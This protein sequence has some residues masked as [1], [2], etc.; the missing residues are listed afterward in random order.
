MY[1]HVR[2]EFSN[3][4][5]ASEYSAA[6]SEQGWTLAPDR[7]SKANEVTVRLGWTLLAQLSNDLAAIYRS[8]PVINP[9]VHTIAPVSPLSPRAAD[10]F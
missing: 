10:H 5:E 1:I 9:P 6:L 2:F 7:D 4:K 8:R 3:R